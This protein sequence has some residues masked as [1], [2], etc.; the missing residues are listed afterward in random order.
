M[1][2]NCGQRP[3]DRRAAFPRGTEDLIGAQMHRTLSR[4]PRSHLGQP[5]CTDFIERISVHWALSV[6]LGKHLLG[7]S[8]A[9]YLQ[10]NQTGGLKESC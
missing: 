2:T 10:G 8:E 1:A 7:V 5:Y 6:V 9:F 4:E 3:A